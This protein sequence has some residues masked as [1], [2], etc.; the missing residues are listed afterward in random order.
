MAL[1]P[2]QQIN[3]LDWRTRIVNDDGTPNNYFIRLWQTMFGNSNSDSKSIEELQTE[4]NA[5]DSAEIQAG[6][7]I[8]ISPDGHLK[9]NPTITLNASIGDLNDVDL[10]TPPTNDQVLVYDDVSGTWKPADQSGGG[11]GST[12][13]WAV[14]A[15]GTGASQNIT[16]PFAVTATNE[17]SVYVNGVYYETDEYT[18]SGTTLTLT[19]NAAGDSIEVRGE[20][21]SGGGCDGGWTVVSSWDFSVSGAVPEII[22]TGLG[23]FTELYL[24]A[25]SVT[26]AISGT[27]EARVST[28]GGVTFWTTAGDYVVVPNTGSTTNSSGFNLHS[29]SATAARSGWANIL[30]NVVGVPPRITG[31]APE[32][33]F[34]VADLVNPIDAVRIYPSGGGNLNGGKIWVLGR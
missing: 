18:V 3:P 20:N 10:S 29:T 6:T 23:N 28:D 9:S 15:T 27:L 8:A 16:L 34:F 25:L 5:L 30:N 11:G 31:T 1:P 2:K 24:V 26:K 32:V 17:V 14:Q 22:T 12:T 21:F 33:R 7:G 13:Y 19:T 4:V